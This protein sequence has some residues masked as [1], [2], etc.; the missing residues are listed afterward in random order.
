MKFKKEDSYVQI[1]R[2]EIF[3]CKFSIDRMSCH[4]GCKIVELGWFGFTW[5]CGDCV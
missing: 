2:L 5:L 1:G 4:S 3:V